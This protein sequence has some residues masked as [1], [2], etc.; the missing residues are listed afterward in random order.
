MAGYSNTPLL[1]K[2]GIK[3]HWRIKFINAPE[4]YESLLGT[5]PILA[6]NPFETSQKDEA[7]TY[8][9]IHLFTNQLESF[10]QELIF[11]KKQLAKHGMIW[12]SWYKKSSKKHTELTEDLIRETALAIGLV[13][14]K[15]CAIDEDWSGLKLVFRLKDR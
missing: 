10:E 2:L 1:K 13:D 5:L 14:V 15:V 6:N 3:E 12:I 9:F 11:L 8:D 4:N 7:E